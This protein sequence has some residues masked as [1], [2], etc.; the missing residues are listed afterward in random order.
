MFNIHV[1]IPETVCTLEIVDEQA[2][3]SCGFSEL[4]P[5]SFGVLKTSKV[6]QRH[7]SKG[8]SVSAR[9]KPGRHMLSLPVVCTGHYPTI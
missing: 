8:E 9:L 2:L 4:H 3:T 5:E 1:T 7:L 6:C